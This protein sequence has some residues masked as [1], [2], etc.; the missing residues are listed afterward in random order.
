MLYRF[1]LVCLLPLGLFVGCFA[2]EKAASDKATSEKVA[3]QRHMFW[4][5]SD[6][7]SSVYLLGSVHFAD[8]TFYPLDSAITNAF[9]RS[10][11]LAV[12]LD[13]TDTAVLKEIAV[14]TEKLGKL[15]A[16]R[17]LAQIVPEDVLKSFDSLCIAWEFPAEILYEYK[18]WAAAMT[19]SS[20]AIMRLGFDPAY[21]IDFFF[22]HRALEGQKKILAIENVS[23]Q[24]DILAGVDV[25]DSLGLYYLKSTLK[26][27][28]LLDSSIVQ[29]MQAWKTGDAALFHTAMYLGEESNTAEDSLMLAEIDER[30][31]ITRNKKMADSVAAFLAQDRNVFIVV[32]A[33][34]MLGK[35]DNVLKLLRD[36]GLTVEQR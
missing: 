9:D 22:L 6:Y 36:R 33:G 1:L 27:I 4:K 5:I 29:M 23:D 10:D 12:E 34:H 8:S 7:N 35:G 3:P 14:Q 19:L 25:S 21:G 13:M 28:H 15:E 26:E 32:G 20:I 2:P 30:V 31:Y 17:S 11:E 16:G 18:P 24:V